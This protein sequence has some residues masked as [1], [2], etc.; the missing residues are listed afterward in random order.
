MPAT[1]KLILGTAQL[2]LNYGINNSIG[3][4]TKEQSLEILEYAVDN[5]ILYLDTAD[6]YGD[7][8]EII[9]DFHLKSEKKFLVITKFKNSFKYTDADKW[10]GE[11]LDKLK[12]KKIHG[13]LFHSF[14][15]YKNHGKIVES[16]N[17]KRRSGQIENVGVSVYDNSELEEVIS[18][19]RIQMVQLPYNLLDNYNRRGKLI[20]QAKANGKV[21]H[22]RSIFLQGL[23]FMDK[24][25]IPLKLQP[26]LPYLERVKDIVNKNNIPIQALALNYCLSSPSIDNVLIGI[27][28]FKQLKQNLA[29]AN[30]KLDPSVFE[31]VNSIN[32]KEIELLNPVNW[33]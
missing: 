18:D 7:A 21:V 17:L 12:L 2:G 11:L 10:I 19:D 6:A 1:N 33:K 24:K 13:Y 5:G 28:S 9:G 29:F 23:F 22:V 16:L 3:K 27:D 30:D 26:L 14:S 32:V 25:N 4:P 31:A 20:E 8:S 15:E